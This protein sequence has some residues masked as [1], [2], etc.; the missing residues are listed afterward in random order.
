MKKLAL[1][2]C[3]CC[4]C[5]TCNAEVALSDLTKV[6]AP[7]KV[8]PQ[9]IIANP[10]QVVVSIDSNGVAKVV[11]RPSVDD[12]KRFKGN[13]RSLKEVFVGTGK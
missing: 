7:A 1:F 6:E 12:Y 2:A 13:K 11:F 9:I 10:N 5:G 8:A 3:I 4:C